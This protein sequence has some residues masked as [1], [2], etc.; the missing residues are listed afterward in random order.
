MERRV[1]LQNA[2]Q[3]PDSA[4]ENGPAAVKNPEPPAALPIQTTTSNPADAKPTTTNQTSAAAAANNNITTNQVPDA[5]A[6]PPPRKRIKTLLPVRTKPSPSP[7]SKRKS[8]SAE[9][10]APNNDVVDDD[11]INKA[12]KD[13][14]IITITDSGPASVVEVKVVDEKPAEADHSDF[15]ILPEHRLIQQQLAL[16]PAPREPSYLKKESMLTT[17]K[18]YVTHIGESLNSQPEA[19]VNETHHVEVISILF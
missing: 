1:Q 2:K 14:A 12:V 15:P 18:P 11:L 5:G 3:K 19:I 16:K 10:E 9:D 6:V 8:K 4:E 7:T 13:G 17:D